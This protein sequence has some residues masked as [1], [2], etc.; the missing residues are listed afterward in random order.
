MRR[1][2]LMIMAVALLL[3]QCRKPEVK[4]PTPSATEGVTVSMTVTAGPGSKTNIDADG[5]I[6]WSSGDKLYVGDGSKCIGCLTLTSGADN[7]TGT[8]SGNVTLTKDTRGEQTFHFYYLG[9]AERTL[10]NDGT[11][12]EVSF[13]EQTGLL[14]DLGSC[15]VGY[16]SANG[17]VTNGVVTGINVMLV[18]KVAIAYFYFKDG[19][20]PYTDALTLSGEHIYNK[21]TVNFSAS[22][23]SFD[24][25]QGDIRL[26]GGNGERYVM[27]VPS[28]TTQRRC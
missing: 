24:V 15:H 2:L 4:F 13:A 18:S 20:T 1:T 8:F 3:T 25:T 17:T 27:L 19:T 5:R 23:F 11:S 10:E 6:T 14:N 7:P 26:S 21:M 9:R 16:G 12:V 28:G 22:D